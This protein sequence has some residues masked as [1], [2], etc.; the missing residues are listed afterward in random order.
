M[1]TTQQSQAGKAAYKG[2]TQEIL[3]GTP[4][5]IKR[6]DKFPLEDNKYRDFEWLFY[7]LT[8]SGDKRTF[9]M[10]P[11]K[12]RDKKFEPWMSKP[13]TEKYILEERE[14]YDE[15]KDTYFTWY[16][17]IEHKPVEYKEFDPFLDSDL[18]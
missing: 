5:Q 8:D 11:S 6:V 2:T 16:D 10:N 14:G 4:F 1:P 3:S 15:K 18:P 7:I 9:R 12:N 17:L 13:P